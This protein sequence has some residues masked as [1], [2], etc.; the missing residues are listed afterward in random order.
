LI[1][2][3]IILQLIGC[4][5]ETPDDNNFSANMEFK[6]ITKDCVKVSIRSKRTLV[7]LMLINA[8][9]VEQR[10]RKTNTYTL[11]IR[12]SIKSEFKMIINELRPFLISPPDGPTVD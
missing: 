11:D 4:S 6:V 12:K 5:S 2:F 10:G 8:L 3:I 9:E 1:E 7:S